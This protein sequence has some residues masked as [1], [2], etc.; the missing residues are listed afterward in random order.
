MGNTA[1]E[2]KIEIARVTPGDEEAF[3]IALAAL[4]ADEQVRNPG[5][6]L[7]GPE[8]MAAWYFHAPPDRHQ[9]AY[10]ATL[11]G[12]PAGVVSANTE[13]DPD[14]ELQVA[15][16]EAMVLPEARRQGV[17]TALVETVVPVLKELGQTSIMSWPC[18]EISHEAGT[19]MCA[20]YGL[21]QRQEERCSRVA[22]ADINEDLM[23][24]WIASAADSAAGYRVESWISQTPD[25]LI[26]LW[27]TAMEGMGDAPLDDL[28]F[29]YPTRERDDQRKADEVLVDAG[30][31][32]FRSLAI[33][34]DGDAAGL[35]EIYVHRER[36]QIGH[37]G[38]TTVLEAHRGHRL[39]K[40]LKAANYRH[41][42]S[43]TPELSVLETYN[44]QSN[45]HMLS[46][47]VAMGFEPHRTYQAWQAPIDE[48]LKNLS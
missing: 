17:A 36:P 46:I 37:Q 21:S 13:S 9:M 18:L 41:A 8:E 5:D 26:D 15:N 38:D 6:P 29:N 4:R 31:M 20:K 39:G 11:N 30:F 40:W 27:C 2:P 10:V 1:T 33:G 28:D 44:A 43:H 22:V 34:P 12:E 32:L 14:D 35:S 19:S 3:A 7:L 45:D 23:S 48:V 47:N 42:A 25:D 24:S 16:I